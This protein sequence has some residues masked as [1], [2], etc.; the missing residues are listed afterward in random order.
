[1]IVTKQSDADSVTIFNTHLNMLNL[2]DTTETLY[3][4]S[5]VKS[6]RC[7]KTGTFSGWTQKLKLG[8]RCPQKAS[9]KVRHVSLSCELGSGTCRLDYGQK[10]REEFKY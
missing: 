3:L 7:L 8:R 5:K 6:R 1:M 2:I 9:H 4:L 10:L